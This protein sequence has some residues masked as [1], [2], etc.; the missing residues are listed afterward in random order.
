[1]KIGFIGIGAMGLPMARNVLNSGHQLYIND[2]NQDAVDKLVDLGAK[3]AVSPKELAQNVDMVILML[4]NSKVIELI[5]NGD[6]GLLAG[7]KTDSYIVNMSSVDPM[8]TKRFAA[9]VEKLNI[10]WIDS[11][12]SGG[13]K[14][15]EAGTLTLMVGCKEEILEDVRPILETMGKIR[16]VGNVGAG[17]GVKMVNNLL[18][19]INMVAISEA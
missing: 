15:A 3:S 12:V 9:Q 19:G 16:Y 7:L 13:T 2:V 10:E 17:S 8:S 6:N 14:G 4:P 5:L 11:P 1:M 18:L